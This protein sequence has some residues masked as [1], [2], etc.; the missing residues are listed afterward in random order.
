VLLLQQL[1]VELMDLLDPDCV[2]LPLDRRV[3]LMPINWG[4]LP[5]LSLYQKR[6][7]DLDKAADFGGHVSALEGLRDLLKGPAVEEPELV[8]SLR[9]AVSFDEQD[10]AGRGRQGLSV[11]QLRAQ[12]RAEAARAALRAAELEQRLGKAP[13]RK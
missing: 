6:L 11:E 10:D 3:R 1:L 2:R 13:A 7:Q 8:S 12:E 4:K 9:S 5:R